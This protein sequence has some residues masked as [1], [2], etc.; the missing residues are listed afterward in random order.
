MHNENAPVIEMVLFKTNE[1]INL[2]DAKRELTKLN[3]CVASM[4]GFVLRKTAYSDNGQFLDLVFWTDL[5]SAKSA[6]EKVMQD[7]KALQ[8]FSIIE[9]K[10]MRFEHFEILNDTVL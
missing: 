7:E 2:E 4:P 10:T 8:V 9:Q 1:G 6:S 3:D 5:S